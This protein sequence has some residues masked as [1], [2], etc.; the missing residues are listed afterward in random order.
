MAAARA[1]HS[2]DPTFS[3]SSFCSV[4]GWMA[5]ILLLHTALSIVHGKLSVYTASQFSDVETEHLFLR[6]TAFA[7]FFQ[8]QIFSPWSTST[9][10]QCIFGSPKLVEGG[11]LPQAAIPCLYLQS[12]CLPLPLKLS[13]V[14]VSCFLGLTQVVWTET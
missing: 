2:T 9:Q 13:P 11:E 12:A 5:S 4:S 14:L 10:E 6:L 3:F 8:A 7:R 1:T